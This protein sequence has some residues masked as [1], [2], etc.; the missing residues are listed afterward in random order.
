MAQASDQ[1]RDDKTTWIAS[2]TTAG[3]AA[4][5]DP[6]ESLLNIDGQTV[7]QRVRL[8]V[9]GKQI[10]LRFSNEFGS[11]PLTIGSA[12]IASG[13]QRESFRTLKFSGRGS[14]TIPAGAPVLSDPVDLAVAPGGEISISLYFPGRVTTPTLHSLALKQTIVSARGDFTAA[15]QIE[16]QAISR[17]FIALSAVLVPELPGQRLVVAFG[18]SITDGDGSTFDADRSWPSVL[19]RRINARREGPPIAVVNQ[20]IAGNRLLRD[21]FGIK[22]LGASGLA[23]FDRDV[24]ALPGV[25]H[26]VMLEGL[27][28][29]GFAGA[30]LGD[31]PLAGPDETFEAD[32]LIGGYRQLIARAHAHGTK[33]IGGTLTPFAGIVG[34]PGYYSPGKERARQAVNTWIRSA[35]TFE[36]VIDFDA[37][38]RDPTNPRRLQARYAAADGLHPNDAGYRAMA[39]AIDIALFDQPQ[40]ADV[41]G[42]MFELNIYHAVPGK[43]SALAS[44]FRAASELQ[45]R[46]GLNV[47]GYWIPQGQAAWSDT[48]VYLIAH[49]SRADADKHWSA[50]HADPEF[51]NYVRA[52]ETEPLIQSVETVYMSPTD[53]SRLK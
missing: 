40:I 24:L 7:R 53:Y 43:V 35:A 33:I 10:R 15:A 27:N 3:H 52:E 34:V 6:E 29:L 41:S 9:G 36:G 47:I 39:D 20:G 49:A 1:A 46:H 21:G 23:R 19:S 26:V 28:D 37:V 14:V 18:D 25:T 4:D 31:L 5:P 32:D 38:L 45:A 12:S 16:P 51:L 8:S 30:T 2:W 42:R 17:S 48:F 44:R 11:A 13:T 22:A 50:F